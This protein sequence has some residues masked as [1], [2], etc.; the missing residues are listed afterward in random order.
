MQVIRSESAAQSQAAALERR[1][2]KTEAAVRGL[3]PP[4]GPGR[5]QFTTGWE[6]ER[7]VATLLA[8]QEAT[9]LLTVTWE[10]QETSREHYVG[11]GRRK[12]TRTTIR[13]QITSVTRDEAAIE[14]L[15]YVI[16]G[17]N[18]VEPYTEFTLR[19]IRPSNWRE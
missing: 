10:R 15:G 3:T 13:Y 5:T 8:E 18:R 11:P 16:E 14:Q 1:L 2:T 7:A 12:T 19:R 17:P 6:L 9:G 4:P